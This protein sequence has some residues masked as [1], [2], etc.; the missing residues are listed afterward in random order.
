MNIKE[1]AGIRI[2]PI[3]TLWRPD[4]PGMALDR[5]A[6]GWSEGT[7]ICTMLK[8]YPFPVLIVVLLARMP[9]RSYAAYSR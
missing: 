9:P 6:R 7:P 3:Y 5:S 4:Y 1:G 2:P 8:T